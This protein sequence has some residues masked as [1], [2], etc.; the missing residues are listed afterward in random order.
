VYNE[1]VPSSA[2]TDP[3]IVELS[4][5][6][7]RRTFALHAFGKFDPSASWTEG[8]TLKK[9]YSAHGGVCTVSVSRTDRGLRFEAEGAGAAEALS[10]LVAAAQIDDGYAS[11]DPK[12]PAIAALHRELPGLRLIRVPWLFDIA[13]SAVL[14]Q[15]V[16]ST[17]AMREWRTICTR[18][19]Q[20]AANGQTAFPSPSALS[21]VPLHEL[22][23]IGI[24]PRRAR[25]LLALA[26]EIRLHPLRPDMTHEQLRLR[27][28][29]VP[30]VGPWTV[31]M[32]LGFGAADTD[33]VPIGDLYLP[34]LV[35]FALA[36]ERR[37]TDERMIQLLEPFRP[38]RFRVVR[39]VYAA[40]ISVPGSSS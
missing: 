10:Q 29:R 21:A 17:D 38:H 33:A 28:G 3:C 14:Q 39:L 19:G 36:G 2:V 22:L 25:T 4:P 6:H 27:L 40:N 11:F 1:P 8:D 13:C 12:H 26:H 34:H 18:F 31:D 37:G 35:S 7:L 9:T 30:G 5:V 24:D 15:R 20:T 23:A 16:R 32:I